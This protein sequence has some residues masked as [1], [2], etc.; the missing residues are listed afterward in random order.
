MILPGAYITNLLLGLTLQSS[1]PFYYCWATEFWVSDSVIVNC[2]PG[3]PSLLSCKASQ[4]HTRDGSMMLCVGLPMTSFGPL[5]NTLVSILNVA[6]TRLEAQ[7]GFIWIDTAVDPSNF[8][9][10]WETEPVQDG[11]LK[12]LDQIQ[13]CSWLVKAKLTVKLD[14]SSEAAPV[15]LTELYEISQ[16]RVT[17][18][19][20][21][22]TH[23]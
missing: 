19:H 8:T 1:L 20:K 17:S 23:S 21:P 16:I 9:I 14:R 6:A 10:E 18:T 7:A 13:R 12:M 3:E 22:V 5:F 11:L 2:R 4:P 15:I